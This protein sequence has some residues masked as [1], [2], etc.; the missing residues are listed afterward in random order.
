MKNPASPNKLDIPLY[1][2]LFTMGLLL[3]FKAIWPIDSLHPVV[4]AGSIL[5]TAFFVA[6]AWIMTS[7]RKSVAALQDDDPALTTALR[8]MNNTFV[9]SVVTF[10]VF[11]FFL[12]I[13]LPHSGR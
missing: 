10:T 9:W 8:S 6:Q 2:A 3:G 13:L 11:S 4:I 7:T 12:S 1:A 5:A